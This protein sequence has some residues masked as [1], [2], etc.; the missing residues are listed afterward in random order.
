[1]SST[2]FQKSSA[3]Y[4]SSRER[5]FK[6]DSYTIV[7]TYS[8]P[9]ELTESFVGGYDFGQPHPKYSFALLS[10]IAV[11][12]PPAG[13]RVANG[14]SD[15]TAFD[16]VTLTFSVASGTSGG[17]GGGSDRPP[18]GYATVSASSA[19]Q[20]I[21]IE[22]HPDY[23]GV[24][25]DPVS[26]TSWPQIGSITKKGVEAYYV[27]ASQFTIVQTLTQTQF[28]FSKAN[29]VSGL[30]EK[31]APPYLTGA[32]GVNWLLIQRDPAI[33]A[34]GSVT[35]TRT[36]LYNQAGWDLEIYGTPT[37]PDYQTVNLAPVND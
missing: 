27:P 25:V 23:D 36:W 12:E 1:M 16:K 20:D 13:H 2:R 33:N 7:E 14:A 4:R 9:T 6:N 22:L 37:S 30:G 32:S 31:Q 24:E 10:Q 17:G 3:V 26:G 11:S 5:V 34:D 15:N 19:A 18:V 35:L 8:S 21:P 28:S 29:L